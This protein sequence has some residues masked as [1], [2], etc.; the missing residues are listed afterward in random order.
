M[1]VGSR[2]SQRFRGPAGSRRSLRTMPYPDG[3][4][5]GKIEDLPCRTVGAVR[6]DLA[7]RWSWRR[8]IRPIPTTLQRPS[9]TAATNP[10]RT[11]SLFGFSCKGPVGDK[12]REKTSSGQ[13]VCLTAQKSSSARMAETTSHPTAA[14]HSATHSCSVDCIRQLGEMHIN[15]LS[16]RGTRVRHAAILTWKGLHTFLKG[17]SFLAAMPPQLASSSNVAFHVA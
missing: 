13:G 10:T 1:D 11:G 2:P 17:Y 8:S 4:S 7:K 3:Q 9:E 5:C 15:C 12:T 16:P 14:K 6:L